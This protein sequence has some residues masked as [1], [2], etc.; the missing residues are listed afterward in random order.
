MSNS[1]LKAKAKQIAIRPRVELVSD[2]D[3]DVL[4][5]YGEIV[6]ETPTNWWGEEVEGDYITFEKVKNAF[7]KSESD[8]IKIHV[9]SIGGD[10]YTSVAISNFLRDSDK[11]VTVIV[12]AIAA[13][14][15]SIIA[16]GADE[17][18]M[19]PNAMMMIHRASAFAYGNADDLVKIATALEK[20][21][22]SVMA[23]YLARYKGEKEEL[24]KLIH[25]ETYLTADDCLSIGLCDE[26][27]QSEKTETEEDKVSLLDTFKNIHSEVIPT[28]NN[29]LT[30]FKGE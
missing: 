30:K 10:V 17:V 22:E 27:I 5:L 21:D 20:F 11:K 3:G 29:L 15:A 26:I 12:D 25:E 1:E 16:M 6:S 8:S 28:N 24:E 13:S 2:G 14:G 18:K 4:Y 23:S 7:A 19:F 9:N